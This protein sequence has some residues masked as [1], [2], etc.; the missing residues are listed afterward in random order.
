MAIRK[1][2]ILSK[3]RQAW[4]YRLVT[5]GGPILLIVCL[6]GIA[7]LESYTDR[8][9][10]AFVALAYWAFS[11]V[12]A[13]NIKCPNCH[14]RWWWDAIM[15][16]SGKKLVNLNTQISCPSCGYDNESVT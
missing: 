3:T 13:F 11:V 1:T 2:S 15:S 7:K 9:T 10:L 16:L 5:W 8:V 4:R 12:L 14:E 6:L